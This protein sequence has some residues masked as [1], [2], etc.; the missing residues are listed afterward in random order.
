MSSRAFD[1]EHHE[2]KYTIKDPFQ[3][4]DFIVP[5]LS[6]FGVREVF[7][8]SGEEKIPFKERHPLYK[9]ILLNEFREED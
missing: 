3:V 1:K 4:K 7:I 6:F 2:I 8:Y 5:F 9:A